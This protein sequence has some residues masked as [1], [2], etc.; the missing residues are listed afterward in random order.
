MYIEVF[1]TTINSESDASTVKKRLLAELPGLKI[2][3]DL[4]DCDRILRI[5]SDSPVPNSIIKSILDK[6]CFHAI[7]L[8]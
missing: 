5:A 2:T 8:E 4:D 6:L 3:F 1:K 7:E